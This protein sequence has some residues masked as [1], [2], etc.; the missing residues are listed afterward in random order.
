SE[1]L[2][3]EVR[4]STV[5]VYSKDREKALE[6]L[7]HEFLDFLVGKAIEPY[8]EAA[9]ALIKMVNDLAYRRKERIVEAL[10][11]LLD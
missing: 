7:R 9:N 1:S 10:R 3:G 2:E 8:R 5:Y 11:R 4:G 6:T